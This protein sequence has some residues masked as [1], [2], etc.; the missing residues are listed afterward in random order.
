M[1]SLEETTIIL[2]DLD[3]YLNA[4]KDLKAETE[5]KRDAALRELE[6]PCLKARYFCQKPCKGTFKVKDAN[7]IRTY[8]YEEPYSCTGGDMWHLGEAQIECPL[9]HT[10]LA[11]ENFPML[12]VWSGRLFAHILESHD[13]SGVPPRIDEKHHD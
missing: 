9:C 5:K 6:I 4:L 2:R 13:R 10:R 8:W 7:L 11:L 1:A 3:A 12:D